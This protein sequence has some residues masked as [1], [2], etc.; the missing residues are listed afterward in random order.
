M[1][2]FADEAAHYE[3]RLDELRRGQLST[4]Q[5]AARRWSALMTGVLGVFGT[6][7]FAGGLTTIDKLA[8][9]YG[10]V[11][12]V[13]TTVAAAT[14]V[15]AVT[16][17]ARASGGLRLD[18]LAFPSGRTLMN[19]E[20]RLAAEARALL[21]TGRWLAA[22]TGALVVAGSVLVLWAPAAAPDP[23]KV[24]VRFPDGA[25]C[26]APARVGGQLTVGGRPLRDAVEIVPV[27]TCPR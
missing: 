8:A 5:A 23:S 7:A 2:T 9:P 25:V 24:L 14:A 16:W 15:A 6:V 4:V 21:R 19:R 10:T 13:L 1:T 3:A 11:A 17:L 18:D 22:A 20:A 12:K 27:G 26:G